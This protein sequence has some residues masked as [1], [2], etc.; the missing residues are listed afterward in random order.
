[1]RT[2]H[3]VI[4]GLLG[5]GMF[6]AVTHTAIMDAGGYLKSGEMPMLLGL[7]LC[8]AGGS[9]LSGELWRSGAKLLAGLLIVGVVVAELSNFQRTLERLSVLHEK[10]LAPATDAQD[11]KRRAEIRLTAARNALARFTSDSPQL[12]A[13]LA[14]QHDT[15][16]STSRAALDRFCGKSCREDNARR[17]DI[18]A[19]AVTTARQSQVRR[20]HVAQ[21]KVRRAETALA[22]LPGTREASPVA[23]WFK[24]ETR[25]LVI[26]RSATISLAALLLATV[27]LHLAAR[28]P[29][30][31]APVPVPPSAKPAEFSHDV[32]NVFLSE[33]I[34]ADVA[35]R[36]G[37]LELLERYHT[38][39]GETDREPL[40]DREFGSALV[41]LI[42]SYGLPTEGEG[43]HRAIAGIA[44]RT[45]RR[46][47]NAE[48]V[49]D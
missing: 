37:V 43:A 44:W 38:W 11:M 8:A 47:E 3:R 23:A 9:Y 46:I 36:I 20:R 48:A 28:V 45:P 49:V 16:V 31:A 40:P 42:Q 34:R 22:A 24:Y 13:A 10:R 1:M 6:A 25:T 18:A 4:A 27:L 15:A 33:T 2:S 17:T 14:R 32:A 12:R 30:A 7:G 41:A 35:G 39:C 29:P 26:T 5:G 21:A 19:A